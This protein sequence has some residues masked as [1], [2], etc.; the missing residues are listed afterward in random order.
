LSG[1]FVR[2]TGRRIA[3]Q[4]SEAKRIFDVEHPFL[5]L[6]ADV[7]PA[8]EAH[9]FALG[10]WTHRWDHYVEVGAVTVHVLLNDRL[11]T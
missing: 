10:E 1:S 5:C 2:S 6:V 4:H 7:Y 11:H 3:R 8:I 9:P